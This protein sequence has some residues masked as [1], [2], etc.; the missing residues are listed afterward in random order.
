MI[1]TL[2]HRLII[3]FKEYLSY[4]FIKDLSAYSNK[5]VNLYSYSPQRLPSKLAYGSAWPNW[6]YDSSVVTPPSS[7]GSLVRGGPEGLKFDFINGRILV[8][9]SNTGLTLSTTVP[10]QEFG[11]VITNQNDARLINE[12]KFDIN[13]DQIAPNT[14]FPPDNIISPVVF[15]KLVKTINKPFA[16]SGLDWTAWHV[17]TVVFA[18]NYF[19]LLGVSGL[20]RDLKER[21]FPILNVEDSPLDVYGDLKTPGWRY[22]SFLTNPTETAFVMESEFDT[23]EN[24][25]FSKIN[26]S[27]LVGIGETE[28]RLVRRP[29]A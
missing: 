11:F 5:T 4:R 14:Y 3:S 23:I 16:L 15:V 1:A 7:I 17:R 10:V 8:G 27:I 21:I 24:D 29:R 9:S 2:D 28:I 22:D 20:I 25:T 19:Q 26:P 13:P 6:V 18:K 12:V